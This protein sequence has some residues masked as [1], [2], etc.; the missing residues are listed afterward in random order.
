MS[1]RFDLTLKA[2]II[3]SLDKAFIRNLCLFHFLLVYTYQN[4][5]NDKNYASVPVSIKIGKKMFSKYINDLKEKHINK[6]EKFITYTSWLDKW[7]IENKEFASH[8]GDNLYSTMGCKIIDMFRHSDIIYLVLIRLSSKEHPYNTLA[9]K[10]KHLMSKK[11]IHSV[12]NLPIKLP[13]ICPP[14]PYEFDLLGSYLLNDVK[15]TEELFIEK[16][17]YALGS[18]VS[19]NNNIFSMVNNISRIPFKINQP[20]LDYINNEVTK[21]NLLIDPYV[22]HK[23]DDLEKRSKYKKSVLASHNS[24]IILQET[25]LGISEFYRRFSKIYF[26]IRLDQRDRLYCTPSYLNYQSNDLSKALLLFADPGIIN[27]KDMES[28]IYLKAYGANC[29]GGNISKASLKSKL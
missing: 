27:K 26:P 11:T 8:L 4:S 22:K 25:I 28:V 5:D 17:A 9:I 2:N 14:K 29:Y 15:F 24:K 19:G 13:M 12:V 18:V 23:F 21:H 7:K 1:N 10:D 3:T 6:S 16:K 20:L